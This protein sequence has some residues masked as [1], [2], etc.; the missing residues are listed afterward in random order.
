[1]D[2]CKERTIC[3]WDGHRMTSISDRLVAEEPLSIQ[4]E[5]KPYVVVMRTP[6]EEIAHAAGLC[7]SEGII[8]APQDVGTLAF[9]DGADTNV[10]AV[11]LS[12]ARRK[13]F[14]QIMDRQLFLSRTSCGI[15]GK[16]VVEDFF[17]W[18]EPLS[19]DVVI[20]ARR[21][22][23]LVSD[24]PLLQPLRRR[25]RST[26]AAALHT[27][28]GDVLSAAEDVGRHNALDK[29]IGKLF[30]E[31][32]LH[33]ADILVLSSR[34]SYELVQKAARAKIS[35]IV[36]VSRPTSLAVDLADKLNMTLACLSKRSGLDIFC[37]KERLTT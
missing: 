12:E 7:L 28:Q 30:L 27:M 18:I 14:P 1:M 9:C 21:V 3:R 17:Q 13:A 11:T 29:T 10:V 2:R 36:A 5:G 6:G 33:Q 37:G 23:K 35:L 8:D 20:E 26:H 31:H 15:C 4:V 22:E 34:I 16:E 19:D 24:L 25:T 32:R